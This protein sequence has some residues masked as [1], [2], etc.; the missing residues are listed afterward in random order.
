MS[1]NAGFAST[2]PHNYAKTSK[3][4]RIP[5]PIDQYGSFGI[6]KDAQDKILNLG[7]SG[8]LFWAAKTKIY[9]NACFTSTSPHNYIKISKAMKLDIPTVCNGS[10]GM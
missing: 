10:V 4:V 7:N 1:Q 3:A 2:S 9:Q 6:K 5:I 8:N